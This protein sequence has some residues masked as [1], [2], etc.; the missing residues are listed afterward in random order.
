[1]VCAGGGVLRGLGGGGDRV[2]SGGGGR[3]EDGVAFAPVAALAEGRAV[4]TGVG[5]VV[6]PGL[7]AA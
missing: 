2:G 7:G 1:V 4:L 6:G 3:I 5:A